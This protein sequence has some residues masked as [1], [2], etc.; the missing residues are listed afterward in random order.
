[1]THG[2]GHDL[3]DLGRAVAQLFKG[4]GNRVVDDLEIAAAGE[5]LELHQ[6]EVGLDP[7]GVA[8]HDKSDRAGGRNDGRLRVAVAVLFAQ[9]QRL[10]P[11]PFRQRHKALVRAIRCVER[12]WGDVHLFVTGGFAMGGTSVIA[13]HPQHVPRVALIAREGS[14]FP[15]DLGRGRVGHAGHHGGQRT[16][17]RAALVAVIAKTHVHQKPADIGIAKP[18]RAEVI[19]QLCDLLRRE[20][21]HHH[22]YFQCQCPEPR[23]M[24]VFFGLEFAVP[25]EGQQVHRRKVA[26]R[27]IEE[28]VLRAGVRPPDR[29][30]FRAG[31]P[32]VDGVVVL[33]ARIGAGPGG[34][35]DLFPQIARLD[36]LGDLAVGAADQ[37]PVG[38][39][40]NRPQEGI[41]HADRVVRVLPRNAGVGLT[42]PVCVIGR[43]LDR[44]V[45][46]PRV[47]E[48]ALDIG[49][50]D[51]I[52]LG[53]ADGVLERPVH[54]GVDRIGQIAIPL[55]DGR[56]DR[57]QAPL[58]H[59]RAG[60]DRRHL[61]LLD[62]LPVDEILDIRMVGVDDHHLRRA[63]RGAARLDRARRTV[64][65]LEKAHQP[66]R[67]AAARQLLALAAQM[68]E[69]GA[70]SRPVLEEPR[71]AHP[72]VHDPPLVHEVVLHTLNEAGMGL[73]ML[74][75][76]FR[77]GELAGLV[78]HI[79]VSLSWAVDAVGPV[80]AGIEPLRAV[81]GRALG[82]Q[83]EAHFVEIGL[84]V[85]LRGEIAALPAPVG[86]GAGQPVEDLLGRGF[87][88]EPLVHGK[89]GQR[90]F[91]G[92]RPPQ[93]LGHV[94][95][96]HLLK[97]RG[98]AGLAEIL[99]R[100]D[101]R[102]DLAPAFGHLH[103]V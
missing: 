78:V 80:Q 18:Q 84:R 6:R 74:I 76:R 21:R 95:F 10:V 23:G 101:V 63:P 49:F 56:E 65:D 98:N 34:V 85:G 57:V 75:R 46:L 55:A 36:G 44:A 5:L 39:F 100:D 27:V 1:V 77:F 70:G 91:V 19:G 66:R 25:E 32:G 67:F 2:I 4:G 24:D 79:V 45:A 60:D 50:R 31:V 38:I 17:K 102:G 93:E 22:R 71:L 103:S 16:A 48:H 72:E 94:L 51:R 37:L 89:L 12:N 86:P 13:D 58:V 40:R 81:R 11:G 47:V 8:V 7:G 68:A 97:T 33:D 30:I 62:H 52:A 15:R 42:V 90:V 83:H 28:H 69:V 54:R 87:P 26:G 82:R 64:A 92:H 96:A 35:A 43:K 88:A 73:R 61:L 99:L 53:L 59:L 29:A 9:L 20:L 3:F 41:G 14:Q